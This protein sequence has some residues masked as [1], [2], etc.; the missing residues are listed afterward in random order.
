MST[1][2]SAPHPLFSSL[3]PIE[4]KILTTVGDF[5][6]YASLRDISNHASIGGIS[7]EHLKRL[8][9][10]GYLDESPMQSGFFMITDLG[11]RIIG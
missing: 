10:K 1:H 2:H 4:Q 9:A 6:H 3:D 11:E 7:I 8:K 5:S